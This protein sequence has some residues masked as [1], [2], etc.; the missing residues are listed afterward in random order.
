MGTLDRLRDRGFRVV[1]KLGGRLGEAVR[2]ANDA[3]GR[4]LAS[5]DELADRRAFEAGY[6]RTPAT[7]AEAAADAAR[8]AAPV[9]VH[10]LAEGKRR[11]ELPKVTQILDDAGVPYRVLPID[12][13][14]AAQ[15]ALRR[16]ANM[17]PPVVFIAG[18]PVGG[19]EHLVNLG[20]AGLRKRVF[21]AGA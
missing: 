8:T 1:G 3:L 4:P 20:R 9:V 18:E 21:G 6:R 19:R 5:A 13:D 16:D 10:T 12:D 14:P 7:A 11:T 17:K 15:A 2:S